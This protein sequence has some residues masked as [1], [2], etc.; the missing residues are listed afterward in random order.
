MRRR[1]MVAVMVIV[2]LG[3]VGAWAQDKP[4]PVLSQVQRLEVENAA[5]RY[6]LAAQQAEQAKQAL[7]QAI[8]GVTP[9]GYTLNLQTMQL[10]PVKPQSS[11]E[12]K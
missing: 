10:E 1:V 9:Q 4:A 11:P 2:L 7:V 12:K 3:A 6:Q 8:Q 5:L